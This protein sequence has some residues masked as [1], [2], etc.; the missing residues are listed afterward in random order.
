MPISLSNRTRI[1]RFQL[2]D[3][4][5]F[6]IDGVRLTTAR[7]ACITPASQPFLTCSFA[8]ESMRSTTFARCGCFTSAAAI[9]HQDPFFA[10]KV[11]LKVGDGQIVREIGT[12]SLSNRSENEDVDPPL[13]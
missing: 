10:N 11:G 6:I 12:V 2:L 13:D 7:K 8:V 3:H 4:P 9:V 1:V 5:V